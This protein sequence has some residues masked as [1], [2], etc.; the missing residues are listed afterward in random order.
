MVLIFNAL[1]LEEPLL[2]AAARDA[3]TAYLAVLPLMV[4][5]FFKFGAAV[6]VTCFYL[7]NYI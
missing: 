3:V 6:A 4:V 1:P 5:G 2:N 7:R